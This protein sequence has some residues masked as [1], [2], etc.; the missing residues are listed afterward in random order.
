MIAVLGKKIGMT[1]VFDES[2]VSIPVT[3]LEVG[4]CV[5]TAVRT[6][7]LDGYEA[8]Q[9]AFGERKEKHLRKSEIGTFKKLGV[10]AHRYLREIRTEK[11]GN[12]H[13]G[14]EVKAD[15]FEVG[16]FVDV[17]GTSIG[18]GFQGV[19]KRHGFRGGHAGHG[20]MFGRVPGSIGQ[21]SNP[22]RV[23]KGMRAA[24]HMGDE[25]VTVQNLKVVKIDAENNLIA[26]RGA[27]PGVEDRLVI[28]R[29]SLKRGKGRDWKVIS[30]RVESEKAK[31]LQETEKVDDAKTEGPKSSDIEAK[32]E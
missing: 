31:A 28:I 14:D 30:R 1:Q 4:P 25:R 5:V 20:S 9:L 2:G 32:K 6:K 22:K 15:N 21:S 3:V 8:V 10:K 19:V 27:V 16:D 13:V 17:V 29:E 26:V 11:I 23:L 24:G 7:E 12:L 18:K